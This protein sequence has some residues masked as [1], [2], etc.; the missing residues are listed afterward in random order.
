MTTPAPADMSTRITDG[1]ETG[2][3]GEDDAR[4]VALT[5]G[6]MSCASCATRVERRLNKLDGVRASVNYATGRA[7]VQAIPRVSLDELVESVEAAGY[8]AEPYSGS[9]VGESAP[10][11]RAERMLWLRLMVAVVLFIPLSDLAILFAVESSARFPGWQLLL[12]ALAAPVVIWCAAPFHRAAWV[13]ARH[14]LGTMDTLVSLGVIVA[15]CWSLVTVYF[16]AH[17]VA[18]GG[19]W[20]ALRSSGSIYLETAAGIT[21][22]VLAGRFFEAKARRSSAGALTALAALTPTDVTVLLRDGSEM[23]LPA[24]ELKVGQRFVTKAGQRIATDGVV[25]SGDAVIDTSAMTG[26]ATPV[27]VAAG[28]AVV[29]GTAAVSGY[30]VCVAT[31][32]GADSAVAGMVAMVERAQEEKASAQRIADRISAVFVPTVLVIALG[33]LAGWLLA[34]APVDHGIDAALA[35]LVIACPCALGLATP[36]ALLVASG[37]AA[38][39]GIFVTGHRALEATRSVSEVIF[40]KTGTITTGVVQLVTVVAAP[41]SEAVPFLAWAGSVEA[42]AG[43]AVA[44]PIARAARAAF[45][46]LSPVERFADF[47]GRGVAGIVAGRE[48]T[49]GNARLLAE[50]GITVPDLLDER[51]EQWEGEGGTAVLVAMERQAVGLLCLSDSIRP[52]AVPAIAALRRMGLRPVLVTGDNA[53]A[54]RH[55]ADQ[56]G[57]DEVIAGVL[58]ADKAVVVQE[59]RSAGRRVAFVGDGINDGPALASADLGMAIGQGTDVAIQAADMILVRSDLTAVADAITLSSDTLRTIRWNFI[60]ALGYNVA[61]IPIAAAGL[62]NPL[63]ASAAMAL[64]SLLVVSNSLR[65]QRFRPETDLA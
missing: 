59:L 49:V 60:W 47:P 38:Q 3:G 22:F 18:T 21:V 28:D 35:V 61:A 31:A 41:G 20:Q 27:T 15:T 1:R 23:T 34:G 14:R 64:S 12:T 40:D 36:T 33:T 19:W 56:V 39:L 53:A 46:E 26:E 17:P 29:G 44:A 2:T 54:A 42:A 50:Q 7:T 32:V 58:P 8:Q 65:L 43:H 13:A 37:R 16:R 63:L 30:L 51:R 55:V 6:G 24:A 4:R 25:E 45:G 9:P 62:A 10:E 52:S 48:V 57:I 11:R 5:I